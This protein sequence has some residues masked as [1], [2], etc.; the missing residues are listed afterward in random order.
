LNQIILQTKLGKTNPD[1]S[2]PPMPHHY[3]KLLAADYSS[4]SP[5]LEFFSEQLIDKPKNRLIVPHF[6]TSST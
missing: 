4:S 2:S 6:N 5:A 1:L 3:P